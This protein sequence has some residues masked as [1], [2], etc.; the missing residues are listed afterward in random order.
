MQHLSP[1]VPA[2]R[3]PG[4]EHREPG[5]ELPWEPAGNAWCCIH[6]GLGALAVPGLG[7]LAV[8]GQ[9]CLSLWEGE[10]NPH[11]GTGDAPAI[12]A[13]WLLATHFK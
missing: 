11:K 12:G 13:A 3:A 2:P 8:P 4:W 1:A 9:C 6:P 7:A 5:W 10:H